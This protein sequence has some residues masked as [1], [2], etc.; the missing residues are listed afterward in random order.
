M[1]LGMGELLIIFIVA[2]IVV[3]PDKLPEYARKFGQALR[4]FR[5]ATGEA[6]QEIREN[7]IEPL[8]EAQ[9]P[10]REAMEPIE[11]M[12]EEIQQEI[13]GVKKSVED[14]SKATVTGAKSGK[15]INNTEGGKIYE[16]G[17][18]GTDSDPADCGDCIGADAD[19]EADK[20][21]RESLEEL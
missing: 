20:N 13:T 1:K 18:T 16:T 15:K 10:L 19:P 6:T 2:I 11:E 8:N 17:D 5:A 4:S 3:G 21:V 14:L 7:V 12:Q 9:K